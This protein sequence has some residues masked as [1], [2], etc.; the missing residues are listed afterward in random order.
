M[1][2]QVEKYG[3]Y[4]GIA[5]FFGLAVLSLL[6]FSQARELKRLR[7]WAGR[8]P[9][10][11]QELEQRVVAQAAASV[12][13]RR[14]AQAGQTAAA[15]ATGTGTLAPPRKLAEMPA[16]TAAGGATAT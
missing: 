3:A 7:E 16:Q 13:G 14:P 5:A 9:E 11:A 6:Y 1:E 2:D 10:R 15:Q 4:V 12:A 8:A